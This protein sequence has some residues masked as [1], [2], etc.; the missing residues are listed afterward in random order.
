MALTFGDHTTGIE[1]RI[2]GS[3]LSYLN[4]YWLELFGSTK[5]NYGIIIIFV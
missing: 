4:K 5:A 2:L 1:Y 3:L